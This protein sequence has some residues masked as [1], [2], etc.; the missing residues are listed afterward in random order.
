MGKAQFADL[1][2]L[3][4]STQQTNYDPG[5]LVYFS[6][7][8]ANI[9]SV[10][11]GPATIRYYLTQNAN[12]TI[13][14]QSIT[15]NGMLPTL[16]PGASTTRNGSVAL[17]TSLPPGVWYIVFA[18]NSPTSFTE[19]NLANNV[20]SASFTVNAQPDLYPTN[21]NMPS[22]APQGSSF[23]ITTT[24]VN[25]GTVAAQATTVLTYWLSTDQSFDPNQDA[26][27]GNALVPPIAAQ[28]STQVSGTV[29][30]PSNYA[31]GNQIFLLIRADG[32]DQYNE[33]IE[34]NNIY[35][36]IFTVNCPQPDYLLDSAWVDPVVTYPGDNFRVYGRV[37]NQGAPTSLPSSTKFWLSRD[38]L[39]QTN[40]DTL[41]DTENTFGLG[42]NTLNQESAWF[43]LPN[44]IDCG[45]WYM[46][47]V[48]D[49]D[50]DLSETDENNNTWH[51]PFEIIGNSNPV[52]T[53]LAPSLC[54]NSSPLALS[55]IPSGGSFSGNG[56]SNNNFS[57]AQAVVGQQ[58]IQY[59][60]TI[61][62]TG[63]SDTATQSLS[64]LGS[65]FSS[66]TINLPTGQ[67]YTLPGGLVVT[68]PGIYADTLIGSNGCDSIITTQLTYSPSSCSYHV[69][70][71]QISC[72]NLLNNTFCVPIYATDSVP[73]G[74]AGFDFSLNYDPNIMQPTGNAY[75]GPVGNSATI[76]TFNDVLNSQVHGILYFTT[77]DSLS[78]IGEIGCVEFQLQPGY[79]PGTIVPITIANALSG[80]DTVCVTPGNFQL[81]SDSTLHAKVLFWGNPS[82][83]LVY[84]SLNS[85]AHLPTNIQG[86][87]TNCIGS[88]P[89]LRP[90]QAPPY[91]LTLTATLAS[92]CHWEITSNWPGT[93]PIRLQLVW[94]LQ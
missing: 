63:C 80:T 7:T 28:G 13:G 75:V 37:T 50:N 55:A 29:S 83:P 43:F 82:K 20:A 57:P 14:A 45:T 19:A 76:A 30:I 91:G 56:V 59:V 87:S 49:A 78:G 24:V 47:A 53:N 48:V 54:S 67:A 1:T 52:I 65:S 94:H 5:D 61:Q 16:A 60:H 33:P 35:P 10:P 92:Q 27:I 18:P 31:C 86:S 71:L 21:P 12:Q 2:T 42:T 81:I 41:V 88:G 9:G 64:V 11:S 51:V 34:S 84:D 85:S 77:L 44:N 46:I 38:T 58:I 73:D 23:P 15:P 72:G 26:L 74:V 8:F 70:D 90:D 4:P 68:S 79:Q 6:A 62:A 39:L 66:Q 40:L 22:S 93:F 17:S 36:S 69:P 32:N 89:T 3:N 25:Q